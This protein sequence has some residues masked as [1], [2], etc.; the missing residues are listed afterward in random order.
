M[1]TFFLHTNDSFYMN[2]CKNIKKKSTIYEKT[3][4]SGRKAFEFLFL[5][6]LFD[7]NF[8]YFVF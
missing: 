5:N 1:N 4:L 8:Y 6:I 3:I 7:I 2:V